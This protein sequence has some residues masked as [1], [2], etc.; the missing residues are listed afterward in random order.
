MYQGYLGGPGKHP[1]LNFGL[2]SWFYL[3][4]EWFYSWLNLMVHEF[5]PHESGSMLIAC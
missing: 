1:T 2:G 5:E 4:V 3:M